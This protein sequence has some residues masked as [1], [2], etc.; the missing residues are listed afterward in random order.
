M[1]TSKKITNN[2]KKVDV[3]TKS[4]KHKLSFISIMLIT[5]GTCIG[6]GIF[7]KNSS[8][9][10]NNEGDLYLSIFS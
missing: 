1:S 7:Y 2:S 10:N 5:V 4:A 9:L 6:A 3:S 8:I